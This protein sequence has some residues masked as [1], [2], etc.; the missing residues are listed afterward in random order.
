MTDTTSINLRTTPK[1]A[2]ILAEL[3]TKQDRSRNYLINQAI[4]TYLHMQHEWIKGVE[5]GMKEAREG[6]LILLDDVMK[7]LLED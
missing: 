4:D 2:E 3:A 7:E 1:K 6:K 5:K